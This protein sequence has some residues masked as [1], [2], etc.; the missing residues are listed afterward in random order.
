MRIAVTFNQIQYMQMANRLYEKGEPSSAWADKAREEARS[1]V[2][3]SLWDLQT[4]LLTLDNPLAGTHM[5][6]LSP[7]EWRALKESLEYVIAEGLAIDP[8]MTGPYD[9]I[10]TILNTHELALMVEEAVKTK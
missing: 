5:V 1:S 8:D 9:P 3:F 10:L 7:E 2:A 4:E 6:D